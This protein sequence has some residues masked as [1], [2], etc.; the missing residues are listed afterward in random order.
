ML[1]PILAPATAL[2]LAG[3]A[4]VPSDSPTRQALGYAVW[5]VGNLL[6]VL[7]G[8]AAENPYLFVLFGLYMGLSVRGLYK[9]RSVI[10]WFSSR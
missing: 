1:D 7:H 10:T 8:I 3:A 2:G 4:L 5:I 6:W 9:K